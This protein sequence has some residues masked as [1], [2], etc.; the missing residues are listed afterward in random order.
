MEMK[1]KRTP[2]EKVESTRCYSTSMKYDKEPDRK[3]AIV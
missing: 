3:V 1:I 2:M